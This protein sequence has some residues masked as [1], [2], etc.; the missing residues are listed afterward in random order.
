[1]VG[2]AAAG[3]ELLDLRR[4]IG[5]AAA[6]PGVQVRPGPD[7]APPDEPVA[8][9]ADRRESE[10]DMTRAGD[11]GAADRRDRVARADP[12]AR[13]YAGV[14]GRE[15][16]GVVTDSVVTQQRHRQPAARGTGVGGAIVL[17]GPV[18]L[19]NEA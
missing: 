18:N 2:A 9:A 16:R 8:V 14:D 12:H 1:M 5:I 4:R 13:L 15:V 11:A 3:E 7:H 19:V 10:V 6:A 17:I